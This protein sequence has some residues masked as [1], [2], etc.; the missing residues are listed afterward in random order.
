MTKT[1]YYNKNYS[2]EYDIKDYGT[3]KLQCINDQIARL[4]FVENKK[5]IVLPKNVNI[6]NL[7]ERTDKQNPTDNAF[8]IH[9]MANYVLEI[10]NK[11]IL[12]ISNIR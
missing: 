3:V 11:E 8:F 7:D 6:I 9:Y 10:D 4:T 1:F 2:V 5:E 12:R